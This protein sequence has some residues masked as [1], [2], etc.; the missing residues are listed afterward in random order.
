MSG[1]KQIAT[2]RDRLTALENNLSPQTVS[3]ANPITSTAAKAL[4]GIAD[5]GGKAVQ[6][7]KNLFK[8]KLKP[9]AT[10]VIEFTPGKPVQFKLENG[11]WK[12]V[13][14]NGNLKVA[15]T[16]EAEAAEAAALK[17]VR[18]H[19]TAASPQHAPSTVTP[20]Q[21][22][23]TGT[24]AQTIAGS[25]EM[26]KAIGSAIIRYSTNVLSRPGQ[27]AAYAF[28][29]AY[30]FAEWKNAKQNHDEKKQTELERHLVRDVLGLVFPFTTTAGLIAME[31]FSQRMNSPF[32]KDDEE[33]IAKTVAELNKNNTPPDPAKIEAKYYERI[34]NDYDKLQQQ[35]G[36]AKPAASTPAAAATPAASN[37]PP[38]STPATPAAATPT[39]APTRPTAGTDEELRAMLKAAGL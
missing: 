7:V 18:Q 16:V 28:F 39:P 10:A 21:P 25:P 6:G 15:T 12:R 29:T 8:A 38:A 4:Q 17:D 37:P 33:Y 22:G 20:T 24:A 5:V 26:T 9:D 2:L 11:I 27:R 36:S 3:E 32:T 14:R 13:D 31:L 34:K 35:K 19:A 30:E 1:S 23:V